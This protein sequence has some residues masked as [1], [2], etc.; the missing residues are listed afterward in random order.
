MSPT[1]SLS[2]TIEDLHSAK[3]VHAHAS[4]NQESESRTCGLIYIRTITRKRYALT[5]S[6]IRENF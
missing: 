6:I 5:L 4:V 2:E 3:V 1:P